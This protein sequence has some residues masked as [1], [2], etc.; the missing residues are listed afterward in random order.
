MSFDEWRNEF[1]RSPLI[2]QD[3][4][5]AAFVGDELAAMTMIRIDE[6]SGRAQNNVTG[7]TAN[8]P[9]ARPGAAAEDPQ[10][11]HRWAARRDDR[12]HGQRRD[13]RADARG[14]HASSATARSARRIEW[15]RVTDSS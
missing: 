5:L 6:P 7:T 15:E 2:D 10:P 13:E 3:A 11:P 12:D 8:V 1:W 4:S 9:Q 14:Q